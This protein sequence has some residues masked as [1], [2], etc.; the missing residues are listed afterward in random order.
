M[1]VGQ[2][3]R[4]REPHRLL[5]HLEGTD[6]GLA[7]EASRQLVDRGSLERHFQQLPPQPSVWEILLI[8]KEQTI[9]GHDASAG[10]LIFISMSCKASEFFVRISLQA[11][12]TGQKASQER[13]RFEGSNPTLIKKQQMS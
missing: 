8:W 11:Y 5:W 10:D 3:P 12:F 1:R 6:A 2:A 13:V 7:N 4:A 9:K